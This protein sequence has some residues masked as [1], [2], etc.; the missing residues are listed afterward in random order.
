LAVYFASDM[1]LRLDHPDRGHRLALWV[2]TLSPDDS[3]YLVGDVCDFWFASRQRQSGLRDCDGLKALAAFRARG[4]MLTVLPGNH[5]RWLGPFYEKELGARFVHEPWV[6]DVH[7]LRIHLVHGHRTGGRQAWKAGMESRAFLKA[8]ENLPSA[9]ADRLDKILEQSNDAGRLRDEQRLLP[10]FRRYVSRLPG[11][12]DIVVFGH[13]H[14]PLDDRTTRLR[15]IV[16]GG[17]HH[18]SSYLRV[19]EHGA[20]LVVIP[21]TEHAFT[22]S[23]PA[24]TASSPRNA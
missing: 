15:M 14:T 9:V 7:G 2:E 20:E 12:A 13:V 24:P 23:T 3:L 18:R 19:D 10:L 4:G 22:Q 16:L 8:F 17:W 11:T 6:V 5:D 1:H 21:P